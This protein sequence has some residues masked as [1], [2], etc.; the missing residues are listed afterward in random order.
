MPP[1]E[2]A[3][4]LPEVAEALAAAATRNVVCAWVKGQTAPFHLPPSPLFFKFILKIIYLLLSF[5]LQAFTGSWAA[6][7]PHVQ[8]LL[9]AGAR[10][11]GH[12]GATQRHPRRC[13]PCAGARCSEGKKKQKRNKKEKINKNN[14]FRGLASGRHT[15]Q[16]VREQGERKRLR[17]GGDLAPRQPTNGLGLS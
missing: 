10:R 4:G 11:G 17:A 12:L 8:A 16:A 3:H 1:S 6:L 14:P 2:R 5:T 15:C 7:W 9:K 13:R